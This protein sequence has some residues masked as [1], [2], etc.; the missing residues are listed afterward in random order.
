[1]GIKFRMKTKIIIFSAIL[2]MSLFCLAEISKAETHIYSLP[3]DANVAG[4]TYVLDSDLILDTGVA[5]TVS[6]DGIV[7]DGNGKS[8]TFA[9]SGQGHG[10]AISSGVTGAE[11]LNFTLN[12]GNYDPR[13]GEIIAA[14]RLNGSASNIKIHDNNINIVHGG[15]IENS[16]GHGVQLSGGF[17]TSEGNE[18]YSNE[19]NIAGTSGGRGIS[20]DTSGTFTGTIRDNEITLT[21]I[22]SVPAGYPRAIS[23][24]SRGPIEVYGNTVNIDSNSSF[25]QG[26]SLWSSDG[27]VIRDNTINLAGRNS[28]AILVDGGSDNNKIY[29]NVIN[30]TSQNQA[31]ENSAGIRLRYGSSN[32]EIYGNTVDAANSSG[33]CMPIRVGGNEGNGIPLNNI[34]HN[35]TLSSQSYV[36][37]LEG[38]S[39]NTDFYSDIINKIGEGYAIN[40]YGTASELV[41]DTTFSHEVF[42][43]SKLVRLSGIQGE[44]STS[45]I[46]FCQSMI[47]SPDVFVGAGIH[48]WSISDGPC[49]YGEQSD[50]VSPSNPSGLNVT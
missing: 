44:L 17:G 15:S 50:T 4:E 3:F 31:G 12:H 49:S 37:S 28:R 33:I 43:G 46:I 36:I 22:T 42:S 10:I 24:P 30:I 5:I 32:N 23:L 19:I 20:L 47:E 40:F 34:F 16:F 7:L 13:A 25:S 9:V 39:Q 8:I 6:A 21:G 41:L 38:A 26:I 11:I 45:G 27:N 18:I 14:I 35:N 48:D 29:S 2:L 1:M